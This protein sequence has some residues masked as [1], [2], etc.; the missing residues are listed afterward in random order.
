MTGADS[1]FFSG[2]F[3][4]TLD[5]KFRVLVPSQ[6]RKRINPQVHGEAFYLVPSPD[7]KRLF[8]YPDLY[9]RWMMQLGDEP[10]AIQSYDQSEHDLLACGLAQ[11][12][13]P[14]KA[15]RILISE[16]SRQRAGIAREVTFVGARNRIEIW[17]KSRWEAESNGLLARGPQIT[18]RARMQRRGETGLRTQTVTGMEGNL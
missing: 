9:Y 18:Q 1:L 6:L 8:M 4:L 11:E 10:E 3:D 5:E 15:G 12:V 7:Q 17:D 16:K 14:D 13:E 2:E